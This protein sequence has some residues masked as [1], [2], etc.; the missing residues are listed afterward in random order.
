MLPSPST[1][2]P[3]PSTLDKKIDSLHGCD[4]EQNTLI[5]GMT[6]FFP[7]NS[8]AFVFIDVSDRRKRQIAD[9]YSVFNEYSSP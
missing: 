2:N 9:F 1:W 5:N 8:I 4:F 6:L 3:R 7:D